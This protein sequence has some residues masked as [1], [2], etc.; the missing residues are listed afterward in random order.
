MNGRRGR[1]GAA[2]KMETVV[3]LRAVACGG[4]GVITVSDGRLALTVTV[5]TTP[6]GRG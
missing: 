6:M 2:L 5:V 3:E 4:G 1:E